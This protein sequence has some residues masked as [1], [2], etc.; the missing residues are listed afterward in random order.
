MRDLEEDARAVAGVLLARRPRR[1]ARGSRAPASAFARMSCEARPLMSTT[2]PKPQASCSCCGIVEALR[3]GIAGLDHRHLRPSGEG[4]PRRDTARVRSMGSRRA[5][6]GDA[7]AADC[8]LEKE[9][10]S[11]LERGCDW[12][13]PRP[14]SAIEAGACAAGS[15]RAARAGRVVRR[16]VHYAAANCSGSGS[17]EFRELLRVGARA[18]R[19]SG[20]FPSARSATFPRPPRAPTPAPRPARHGRRSGGT[21]A[22]ISRPRRACAAPRRG[23]RGRR[24]GRG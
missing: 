5:V 24:L 10:C 3:R 17:S 8:S 18:G 19:G 20:R 11:L 23:R 22:R 6:A 4:L 14:C 9:R 2:K 15:G 12:S 7:C 21:P 16:R 13:R 1:G